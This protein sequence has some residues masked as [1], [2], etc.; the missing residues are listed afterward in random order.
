MMERGVILGRLDALRYILNLNGNKDYVEASV[1]FENAARETNP[2]LDIHS[3]G[4]QALVAWAES[5][6]KCGLEDEAI[7]RRQ[8]A[9]DW[10]LPTGD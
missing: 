8:E 9:R 5:L 3:A 1:W 6:E 2:L 10:V 4:D 7:L